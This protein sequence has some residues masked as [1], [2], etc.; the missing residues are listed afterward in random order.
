MCVWLMLD[1]FA[2]LGRVLLRH[3]YPSGA[4]PEAIVFSGQVDKIDDVALTM[5]GSTAPNAMPKRDA[6]YPGL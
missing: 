6:W 4:N 1:P 5:L 2:R 3:G